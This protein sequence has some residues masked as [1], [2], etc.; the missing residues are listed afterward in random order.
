MIS[1]GQA[2]ASILATVRRQASEAD[3]L[4]LEE[5][6]HGCPACR[7]EKA[8][9]LLMER[10]R[11]EPAPHLGTDA[12]S[13]VL[14]HLTDLPPSEPSL[15]PRQFRLG[16]PLLAFAACLLVASSLWV[17]RGGASQPAVEVSS[18]AT[19]IRA[20]TAGVLAS[21]GAQ[22]SYQAGAE[23]HVQPDRR[24]VQLLA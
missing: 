11:E 6:L 2:R 5:H 22:I 20:R 9:W 12:R 23:F 10:L 24:E 16:R 21:A 8:R 3:R 18:R 19:S 4:W 7:T 17:W 1:C 15:E 13:R 14:R